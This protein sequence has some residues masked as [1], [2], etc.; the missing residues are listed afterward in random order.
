MKRKDSSVLEVRF[1]E[2]QSLLT[3]RVLDLA[4]MRAVWLSVM[5]SSGSKGCVPM[6]T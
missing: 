2:A 1:I 6:Q 4:I 5:G 3:V